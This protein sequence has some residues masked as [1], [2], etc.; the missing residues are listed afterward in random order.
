MEAPN[1][2]GGVDGSPVSPVQTYLLTFT[3]DKVVFG[4]SLTPPHT[5]AP[6][7][8]ISHLPSLL[9]CRAWPLFGWVRRVRWEGEHLPLQTE[10]GLRLLM[11]LPAALDLWVK[12]KPVQF[13]LERLDQATPPLLFEAKL[14]EYKIWMHNK[15]QFS[16]LRKINGCTW[17]SMMRLEIHSISLIFLQYVRVR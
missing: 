8:I 2:T 3:A 6:K 5:F 1:H 4:Q 11:T 15:E 12:D 13:Q 10:L 9:D 16:R 7:L 14:I 17:T